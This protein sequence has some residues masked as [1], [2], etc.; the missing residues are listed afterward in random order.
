MISRPELYLPQ[1][2][3]VK[4][5]ASRLKPTSGWK[6]TGH[7]RIRDLRFKIKKL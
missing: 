5:Q 3:R 6:K 1:R 2:D 4:P 7:A